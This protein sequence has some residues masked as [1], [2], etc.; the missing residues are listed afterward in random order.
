[1]KTKLIVL[2]A[3]FLS[4]VAGFAQAANPTFDAWADQFAAR[5]VKR[6]PQLAT[7]TQYFAGAEQDALDRQLTLLGASG[8]AYGVKAARSAPSSRARG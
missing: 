2:L 6:N 5:W 1:M 3:V 4:C 7:R 8:Q